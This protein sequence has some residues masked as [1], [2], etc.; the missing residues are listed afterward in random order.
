MAEGKKLQVKISLA[1][2]FDLDG[3]FNYGQETFGRRQAENYENE[4]WELIERLSNSYH[5]FPECRHLPT[6]SK[7]YRWIILD[8]HLII[9][10]ITKEEVQVLRMLHTKRSIPKS[11]RL[12]E[13]NSKPGHIGVPPTYSYRREF[14]GLIVAAF[15]V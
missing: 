2:L 4:I 11:K 14:T 13:Q 8:A 12:E 9:Y 5:L 7:M 1:F 10:R 6:R 3:V 15:N